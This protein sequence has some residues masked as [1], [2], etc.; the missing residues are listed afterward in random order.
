LAVNKKLVP[1]AS[2]EMPASLPVGRPSESGVQL[3][4]PS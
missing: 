3:V 1:A 2:E 4:P